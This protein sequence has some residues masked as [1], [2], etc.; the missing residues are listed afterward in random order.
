M[1]GKSKLIRDRDGHLKR[2]YKYTYK[3]TV[4]NRGLLGIPHRKTEYKTIWL[5]WKDYKK[6][7][8]RPYTI[9]EMMFY[10]ELFGDD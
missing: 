4:W 3:A 6:L 9:E 8:Y 7:R 5:D 10:D 1:F 2:K